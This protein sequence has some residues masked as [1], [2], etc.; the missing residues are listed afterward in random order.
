MDVDRHEPTFEL[1]VE[2]VEKIQSL[3][4]GM[5]QTINASDVFDPPHK[6]RLLSRLSS[7]EKEILKP[8]G[9][10]DVILGGMSDVGDALRKFGDDAKPI[11]DRMLEIKRIVRRESEEYENLPDPD[12]YPKLPAP[13]STEDVE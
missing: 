9:R 1:Q 6:V 12:I 5:R 10:L 7:I 3:A 8:L 4:S 11:V 13:D 2:D